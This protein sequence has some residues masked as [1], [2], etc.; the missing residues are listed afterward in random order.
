VNNI[1]YKVKDF[2]RTT[3]VIDI[4]LEEARFN[5]SLEKLN[6]R[7][8]P[9]QL[10]IVDIPIEFLEKH[11]SEIIK[12]KESPK[13]VYYYDDK[14]YIRFNVPKPPRGGR[15]KEFL[16]NRNQPPSMF[17]R[18]QRIDISNTVF[19]DF[20]E[21]KE[22]QIFWFFIL[23]I[24]NGLL[25]GFYLFLTKKIRPLFK[26]KNEIKKFADGDLT[27]STKTKGN[28]EIAQVAN[29]FDLAIK[30]VRDLTNSRNLFLRNIMHE[31]KTPITKGRLVTDTYESSE[32]QY[33]LI[34]VFQRLEYL[35]GEFSKIEELTSGK[36]VLERK[37]FRA[38]DLIDQAL[39]ILL[40]D[41]SSV[42]IYPNDLILNVDFDLFSISL[43]NL[44]DNALKYSQ[45]SVPGV[46]IGKNYI[47]VRNEGVVLKKDIQEYY[48]PFN[49]EYETSDEGLG[50]GLYITHNIIEIHGYRLHYEYKDSYH[51]FYIYTS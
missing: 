22:T 28:D 38:I 34:R 12:E 17:P 13:I 20:T 23:L 44:I 25:V 29:E 18:P 21:G 48:E 8:R 4:I 36:I 49:H 10:Q 7:I 42:D 33:I 5:T 19:H 31:L 51:N 11:A 40:I 41:D 47:H 39:D 46:F 3:S 30:Q 6:T 14:K 2:K 45:G 26:L 16:P 50:L 15:F 27:V 9:F 43:K 24:I 32:R 37:D 1:T 35:L